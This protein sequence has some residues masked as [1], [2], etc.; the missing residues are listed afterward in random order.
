VCLGLTTVREVKFFLEVVL[1]LDCIVLRNIMKTLCKACIQIFSTLAGTYQITN[2]MLHNVVPV[3]P[4]GSSSD[5][6]V[7]NVQKHMDGE[8]A[9]RKVQSI[10]LVVIF[11][12]C[13]TMDQGEQWT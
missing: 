10:V 8:C 13:S 11:V 6:I 2:K 7:R 5:D 12:I 3:T 9:N 4:H 1:D